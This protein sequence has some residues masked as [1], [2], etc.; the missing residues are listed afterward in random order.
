MT[1]SLL[2]QQLGISQGALS[3]IEHGTL[4]P[5]AHQWFE[6]C[7]LSNVPSDSLLTG[8]IERLRPASLEASDRVGSFKFPIRY[9]TNRGSKIRSTKPFLNFLERRLGERKTSEFFRTRKIDTDYFVDLDNQV[10]LEF[11]LDIARF[12]IQKGMLDHEGM[13][14]LIDPVVQ[15]EVHG[16]LHYKYLVNNGPLDVIHSLAS[17]ARL[18]GCNFRFQVEQ[19][20]PKQMT[21]S[22]NPE[23]HLKDFNY[24]NDSTLG[25]FLCR[26]QKNYL[27]RF[28]SYGRTR[29]TKPAV[30]LREVECH[31]KSASRCV[32]QITTRV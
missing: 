20:T 29:S 1:Q 12:S 23:P 11:V 22:V 15:P 9:A 24:R 27:Q 8:T 13:H 2:C 26:Y 4:I 25:D 7:R 3:K 21:V 16:A 6:F 10:N 14:E 18:Y 19:Y 30:T 31:Y 28:G 32:Y 17:N 5:S